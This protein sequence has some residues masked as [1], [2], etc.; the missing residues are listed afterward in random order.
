MYKN[1][2]LHQGDA[3]GRSTQRKTKGEL[4]DRKKYI[5]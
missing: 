4:E 1:I 2:L 3:F 5:F